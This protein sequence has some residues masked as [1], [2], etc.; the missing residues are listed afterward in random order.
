[1]YI[2]II[3]YYHLPAST[4]LYTGCLKL[5]V[6]IAAHRSVTHPDSSSPDSSP[7]EVIYNNY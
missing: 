5:G 1:M 6:R 2:Y 3:A 7:P 4:S